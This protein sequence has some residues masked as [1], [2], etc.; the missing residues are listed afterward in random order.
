MKFKSLFIIFLILFFPFLASA[1]GEDQVRIVHT[2]GT[3]DRE[4]IESADNV[5]AIPSIDPVQNSTKSSSPEDNMNLGKSMIS[6]GLIDT[7]YL[8]ADQFLDS[9]FRVSTT[10][11]QENITSDSK[12][13][14]YS[15]FSQ[16]LNPFEIPFIRDTI[17]KT[18]GFYYICALI[19][20]G[21]AYCV[22]VLQHTIPGTFSQIREGLTGEE[23]FFDFWSMLRIWG[24]VLLW[25]PVALGWIWFLIYVRNIIVQGLATQLI[26]SINVSSDSLP[27]Y[28]ISC[29]IWFF[30][31]IQKLIAEYTVYFFVAF[32]FIIG[33]LI[34]AVALFMSLKKAAGLT[35]FLN[36]YFI[37]LLAMDVITLIIIKFGVDLM[38]YTGI[39]NFMIIAMIVSFFVDFLIIISPALYLLFGTSAGRRMVFLAAV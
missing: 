29:A 8:I 7:A 28:F 16:S 13:F 1:D 9:G 37:L 6:G 14:T 10:G 26:D 30:N 21:L 11:L 4:G 5:S 24:I 23:G 34:A 32:V 12:Q 27:L 19:I 18:G 17:I 31:S 36:V 22:F 25:P 33:V 20:I 39:D 2:D 15:L 35:G 3:I 38:Q